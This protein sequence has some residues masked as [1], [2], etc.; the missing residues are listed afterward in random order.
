MNEILEI[1]Q[2]VRPEQEF[3][4]S[5]NFLVDGLLESMDIIELVSKLEEK[6]KI[7]FDVMDLVPENFEN[8][9]AIQ[10]LVRR[11]CWVWKNQSFR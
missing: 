4:N 6:Y 7:E 8:I 5:I 9:E 1:L 2:E 10:S 11:Y 3:E